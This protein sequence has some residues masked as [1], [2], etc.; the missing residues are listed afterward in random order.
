MTFELVGSSTGQPTHPALFAEYLARDRVFKHIGPKRAA[1]LLRVLG[2]DLRE[3]MLSIDE[4]VVEIIGEAPAINAAAVLETRVPETE[5]LE[6]LSSLR[7]DIPV[8]KA[9]RVA[10]AWG[11]Q[12][13]DAVRENPYLL[14]AVSDW[15]TVDQIAASLGISKQDRRREVAAIEAALMGVGGL[16][17][18]STLMTREHALRRAERLTGHR[19]DPMILDQAVCAGA[20]VT[21]CGAL[22]P[23]KNRQRWT[24]PTICYRHCGHEQERRQ[25]NVEE[26]RD[27]GCIGIP[28]FLQQ[29]RSGAILVHRE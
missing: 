3:A 25:V 18:G 19:I 8:R 4:R 13:T 29:A 16:R 12:G 11:K 27:Q 14:L 17:S 22:Q 9:I 23:C 6:W 20:A 7:A 28:R 2:A 5:F 1:A 24:C 21:L 15:K 26:D 10:R